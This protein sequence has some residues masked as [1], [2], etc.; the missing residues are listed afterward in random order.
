[1][2]PIDVAIVGGGPAGLT[3]ALYAARARSNTVVFEKNMPGGQIIT[4]DWLE[5]YPG[6]HEG[7]SGAE[8][9]ELMHEHAAKFGAEFRTFEEVESIEPVDMHFILAVDGEEIPARTVILATGAIPARLDVPGE[10]DYAGRGVSW[11]ATCDGALYKDKV[12]A[13]VGGGDAA[14]EE[15]IFLTKFASKVYVIHRRDELRATR[16]IQERCFANDKI[17]VLWSRVVREIEGDGTRVT[18][19]V[20]ESTKGEDDLELPL[21]G[22]FEFVGVIPASGL[23]ADIVDLDEQGFVEI[24]HHGLTSQPGL[25][26]AGDV[27]NYPLKQVVTA[28]GQGAAAADDAVKHIDSGVCTI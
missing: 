8:I 17:E 3:A 21:D 11:C 6:F 9:G 26:A 2:E 7:L 13:V 16:C 20:L 12:V 14:I 4:T 19:I 1:V 18:G 10:S 24:D 15:A 27:T 28:A 25:Y 23:V 22:V 5:N